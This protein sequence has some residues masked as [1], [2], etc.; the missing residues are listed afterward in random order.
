MLCQLVPMVWGLEIPLWRPVLATRW[1]CSMTSFGSLVFG[2]SIRTTVAGGSMAG[3][4]SLVIGVGGWMVGD[5]AP[6]ASV[7]GPMA[8]D[9]ATQSVPEVR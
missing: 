8:R 9:A 3:Y 2:D 6:I 5:V 4:F 7:G 1:P